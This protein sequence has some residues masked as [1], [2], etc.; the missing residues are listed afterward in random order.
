MNDFTN[1]EFYFNQAIEI[2]YLDVNVA[3]F[4]DAL[5]KRKNIDELMKS[6]FEEYKWLIEKCCEAR[7]LLN[8]E[9]LNDI[10]KSDSVY[11]VDEFETDISKEINLTESFKNK[12]YEYANKLLENKKWYLAEEYYKILL[13]CNYNVA[14]VYYAL[15][16]IY[17]NLNLVELSYL[18]YDR[19]FKSSMTFAATVLPEEHKNKYYLYAKGNSKQREK[20]PICGNVGILKSCYQYI[21]DNELKDSSEIV[22]KYRECKTCSHIFAANYI[23]DSEYTKVKNEKEIFEFI[24]IKEKLQEGN[25]LV[26]VGENDVAY[27]V[28]KDDFDTVYVEGSF[29]KDIEL[30]EIF[31]KLTDNIERDMITIINNAN[32]VFNSELDMP[33]WARVGIKNVYTKKSISKLL[34][35]NGYKNI[36]IYDSK[37]L[38]GKMIV[39]ACKG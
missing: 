23:V 37:F 35:D 27:K 1:A 33:I 15:G 28:L 10:D 18:C 21:E 20:C 6:K 11:N 26:V 30:S 14:K 16:K 32:S 19:A 3:R 2:G 9:K 4:Y 13:R 22:V 5:I 12:L 17:N 36:K 24:D 39:I 25:K 8:C 29:E 7:T 38:A 34:Q 31:A